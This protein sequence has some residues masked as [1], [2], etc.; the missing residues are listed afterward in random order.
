MKK[1]RTRSENSRLTKYKSPWESDMKWV[2]F[3][4]E[5]RKISN[6]PP[7]PTPS[8]EALRNVA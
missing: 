2:T 1:K 6:Y 8:T 5:N 4:M 7:K 3:N